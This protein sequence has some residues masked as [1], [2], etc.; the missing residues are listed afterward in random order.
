M[1]NR[2]ILFGLILLIWVFL[3]AVDYFFNGPQ[4]LILLSLAVT[5]MITHTLW[6]LSAQKHWQR[7]V[8]KHKLIGHHQ[9]K[10]RI[11]KLDLIN[12]QDSTT[13]HPRVDI[14]I[15]AKNEGR[16]IETTIRNMFKLDYDKLL[17]WVINDCSTDNMQE[18]LQSLTGEFPHLR[19]VNRTPGSYPGKISGTKRCSG[20]GERRCNCCF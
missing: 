14:F 8:N 18:V 5:I 1:R 16:V 13:W 9:V 17:L 2:I 3:K 12:N 6:L 4:L 7:K 11:S 20:F 19:I 10:P 15:A